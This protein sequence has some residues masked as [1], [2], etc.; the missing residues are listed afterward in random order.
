[1][2]MSNLP[3]KE[4]KIMIIKMY[5]ELERIDEDGENFNS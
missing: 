1:M 2:E 4:L 5:T 3:D